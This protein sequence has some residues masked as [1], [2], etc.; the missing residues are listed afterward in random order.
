VLRKE[1]DFMV[2]QTPPKQRRVFEHKKQQK[3]AM[4]EAML[5]IATT[6]E[7]ALK[8]IACGC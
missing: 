6:V 8:A 3:K 1:P 7:K 5:P 4:A 2:Q